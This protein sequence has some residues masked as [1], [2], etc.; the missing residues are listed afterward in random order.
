MCAWFENERITINNKSGITNDK[1]CQAMLLILRFFCLRRC[2][3]RERVI[4]ETV[5]SASAVET[6]ELSVV[7]LSL[8]SSTTCGIRLESAILTWSQFGGVQG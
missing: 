5:R 8:G 7:G 1:S 4:E 2:C 3:V 6:D